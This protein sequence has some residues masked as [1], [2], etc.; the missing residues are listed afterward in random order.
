MLC[1]VIIVVYE[2]N[3]PYFTVYLHTIMIRLA[4]CVVFCCK[5]EI[6]CMNRLHRQIS[7]FKTN[8]SPWTFVVRS[9]MMMIPII[10]LLQV[11]TFLLAKRTF[12]ALP[13]LL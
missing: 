11:R 7:L 12:R 3:K 13:I 6:F 2:T 10:L 9:Y 4:F 1:T 8:L 5:L